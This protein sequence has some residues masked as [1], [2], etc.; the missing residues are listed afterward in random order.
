MLLCASDVIFYNAMITFVAF[1]FVVMAMM[2]VLWC[3]NQSLPVAEVICGY[4]HQSWSSSVKDLICPINS[5]ATS[6]LFRYCFICLPFFVCPH[7]AWF[8]LSGLG[9]LLSWYSC[10]FVMFVHIT[11][12]LI[13]SI[14][15][16]LICILKILFLGFCL[17]FLH[18][19]L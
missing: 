16:I 7:S 18:N 5:A 17:L 10:L 4:C 3:F 19:V 2:V 15:V 13:L 14:V 11:V 9:S 8:P 6:T 12:Y 1:F